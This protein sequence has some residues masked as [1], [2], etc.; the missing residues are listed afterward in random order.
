MSTGTQVFKMQ[1]SAAHT[2]LA[3][4]IVGES[5]ELPETFPGPMESVYGDSTTPFL[6]DKLDGREAWLFEFDD[7][8]PLLG[9]DRDRDSLLVAKSAVIWVDKNTGQLLSA[10]IRCADK[11]TMLAALPTAERAEAERRAFSEEYSDLPAVQTQCG[12]TKALSLVRPYVMS[13]TRTVVKF[14]M[15][16]RPG[17]RNKQVWIVQT[18]G[19]K[20]VAD[21]YFVVDD[22][23]CELNLEMYTAPK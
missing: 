3:G 7:A 8:L 12:L 16:S 9:Y 21:R 22:A 6:S 18:Y 17:F 15:Y 13:S 5:R 2:I 1:Y 23:S 14:V 19:A 10:E 20:N 4:A 11:S